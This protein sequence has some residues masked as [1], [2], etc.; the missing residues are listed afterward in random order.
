MLNYF[1]Y[2]NLKGLSFGLGFDRE[3]DTEDDSDFRIVLSLDYCGSPIFYDYWGQ[4]MSFI[5]EL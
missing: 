4:Q 2:L 3:S 1:E 5:G